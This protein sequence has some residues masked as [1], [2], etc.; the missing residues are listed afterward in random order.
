MSEYESSDHKPSSVPCDVH[1]MVGLR[2]QK[3]TGSILPTG[4]D[5]DVQFFGEVLV[6][7]WFDTLLD[8][9]SEESAPLYSSTKSL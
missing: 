2:S 6:F 4:S 5:L 7:F 1:G 8:V 3:V 9:F